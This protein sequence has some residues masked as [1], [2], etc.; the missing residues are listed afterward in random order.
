M[1]ERSRGQVFGLRLSP[2]RCSR[3]PLRG[4]PR[5]PLWYLPSVAQQGTASEEACGSREN[6]LGESAADILTPEQRKESATKASKAAC[7]GTVREG[8]KE[9]RH[10]ARMNQRRPRC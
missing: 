8:T 7:K 4:L 6:G 10:Q 9:E 1:R 3:G 5:T 2:V